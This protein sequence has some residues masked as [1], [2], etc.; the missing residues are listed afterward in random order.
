MVRTYSALPAAAP[1]G[2]SIV[3]AWIIGRFDDP[4]TGMTRQPDVAANYWYGIIPGTRMSGAAVTCGCYID[5]ET[6]RV[7]CDLIATLNLPI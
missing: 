5:E 1:Q 3:T 4:Y 7:G 6:R 2:S